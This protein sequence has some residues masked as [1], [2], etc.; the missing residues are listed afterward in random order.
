MVANSTSFSDSSA[1]IT[2]P[3]ATYAAS[4]SQEAMP[5]DLQ[6][7]NPAKVLVSGSRWYFK[8][9]PASLG[10]SPGAP[11]VEAAAQK[12]LVACKKHNVICGGLANASDIEQ[13]VK[14]GWKYIDVGRTGAGLATG[15]AAALKA[16][17]SANR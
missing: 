13:K 3:L 9:L 17:Q 7:G 10:V 2:R 8:D 1:R 14:E 16:G 12:V 15:T 11:E 6:P 4:T 5:G